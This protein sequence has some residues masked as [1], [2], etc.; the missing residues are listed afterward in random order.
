MALV[1]RTVSVG[2]ATISALEPVSGVQHRPVKLVG[3]CSASHFLLKMG[4]R[5]A[6][7]WGLKKRDQSSM[8]HLRELMVTDIGAAWRFCLPFTN[9]ASV[10]VGFWL[11][12]R[13]PKA[14][15][16]PF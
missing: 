2:V 4:S 5:Q 16:W 13:G 15:V 6:F 3:S 1:C 14:S 10:P 11:G 9:P 8:A 12:D 7:S